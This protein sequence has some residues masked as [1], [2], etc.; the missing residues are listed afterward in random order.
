MSFRC[1]LFVAL[2]LDLDAFFAFGLVAF[3]LSFGV[4]GFLFGGGEN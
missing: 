1:F 3:L 2:V 4:L